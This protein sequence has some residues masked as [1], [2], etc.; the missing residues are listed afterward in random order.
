MDHTQSNGTTAQIP[1][2]DL[3]GADAQTADQLV[4]AVAEYGFVFVKGEGLDFTAQI[5]NDTFALVS[6]AHTISCYSS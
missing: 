6:L 4:K 2:I 1:V 5:L 3:S